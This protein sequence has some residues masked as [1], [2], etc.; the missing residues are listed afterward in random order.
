MKMAKFWLWVG[1]FGLAYAVTDWAKI[2]RMGNY[3][4][5]YKNLKISGWKTFLV[6]GFH[7]PCPKMRLP[8]MTLE[9]LVR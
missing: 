7:R 9:P 5:E 8:T 6:N 4:I 3:D 2:D 1:W